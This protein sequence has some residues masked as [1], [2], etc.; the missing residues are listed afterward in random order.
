M[1]CTVFGCQN[2]IQ[3]GQ[4]LKSLAA[5]LN[6]EN[7]L[8][9]TS[10]IR[11]SWSCSPCARSRAATRRGRAALGLAGPGLGSSALRVPDVSLAYHGLP[12]SGHTP[13]RHPFAAFS[14]KPTEPTAFGLTVRQ[15]RT[16]AST[17]VAD[18]S[19]VQLNQS[20]NFI[21]RPKG[22]WAQWPVNQSY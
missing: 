14:T 19:L 21:L 13:T 16:Q 2:F 12:A 1:I 8:T 17:A 18:L 11:V 7:S 3:S 15:C 10:V 5:A 9:K 20:Q 4:K 22:L 6:P